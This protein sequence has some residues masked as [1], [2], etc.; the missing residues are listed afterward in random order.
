MIALSVLLD[1]DEVQ[2]NIP[3]ATETGMTQP[4]SLQTADHQAQ[5]RNAEA[6]SADDLQPCK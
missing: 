4:G 5:K 1:P 2:S 3:Q 6:S